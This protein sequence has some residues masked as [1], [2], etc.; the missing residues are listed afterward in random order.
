MRNRDRLKKNNK[1][2]DV[3]GL[4]YLM[5]LINKDCPSNY[6]IYRI[7]KSINDLYRRPEARL[8]GNRL[9]IGGHSIEIPNYVFIEITEEDINKK[10]NSK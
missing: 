6:D 7:K 8:V 2:L 1:F 4:A 3:H 10:Y 5:E 9:F